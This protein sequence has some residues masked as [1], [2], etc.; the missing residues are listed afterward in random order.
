MLKVNGGWYSDLPMC[1]T[2]DLSKIVE[3]LEDIVVSAIMQPTQL[4]DRLT[5]LDIGVVDMVE[6][7][8]R[9]S[10][11]AIEAVPVADCEEQYPAKSRL[12]LK[13]S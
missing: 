7:C 12:C 9:F 11:E 10:H 8:R 4:F 13:R 2:L 1:Y 3:L 6:E 5:R